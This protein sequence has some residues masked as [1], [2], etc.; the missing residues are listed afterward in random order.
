[1]AMKIYCTKATSIQVSPRGKYLVSKFIFIFR[2]KSSLTQISV[3]RLEWGHGHAI[4]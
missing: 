1:M 4:Q 3:T 2:L